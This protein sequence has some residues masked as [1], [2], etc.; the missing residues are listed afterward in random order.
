MHHSRQVV[1]LLVLSACGGT[2]ASPTPQTAPQAQAAAPE[3][4]HPV[5]K[6][7]AQK[8]IVEV[9]RAGGTLELD[10]GARLE[11][12]EGA[13]SEAVQI[14]FAAGARTTAFSNK[15][16]ERPLGPT[17][18]IAPELALSSP[19]TVSVPATQ[20]PEGFGEN[21]LA[22]G[23]EILGDQRAVEMQGVQTRWDYFPAASQGGRA[24]AELGQ[25]P[26]YRVQFV[27]SKSE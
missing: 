16:H 17:L 7:G 11:I 21:D 27:V 20:L 1:C 22:L 8:L 4:S 5:R 13:L 15:E 18:E 2:A 9:G 6:R 26:G 24:V 12:P 25:V 19:I 23:L 3:P 14:T 10:N